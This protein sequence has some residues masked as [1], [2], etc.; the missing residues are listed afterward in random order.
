[1]LKKDPNKETILSVSVAGAQNGREAQWTVDRTVYTYANF[2]DDFKAKVFDFGDRL[3]ISFIELVQRQE[4]DLLLGSFEKELRLKVLLADEHDE[5]S[6][7][8]CLIPP[9][10]GC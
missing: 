1:M 4:N 7:N 8:I 5:V 9:M 2:Y 3:K 10:F 6:I